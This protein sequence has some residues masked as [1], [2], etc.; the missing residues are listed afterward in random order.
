MCMGKGGLSLQQS[1]KQTPSVGQHL[2]AAVPG[3]VLTLPLQ[4]HKCSLHLCLDEV[5]SS[6]PTKEP[7]ASAHFTRDVY[8]L[9]RPSPS[10]SQEGQNA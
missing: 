3:R 1:L 7:G 8:A 6:R 4:T 2:L 9:R 5:N 10:R